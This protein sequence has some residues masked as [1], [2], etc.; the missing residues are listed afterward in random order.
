VRC[1]STRSRSRRWRCRW[2]CS[3]PRGS[4][5]TRSRASRCRSRTA[6]TRASSRCSATCSPAAARYREALR[7]GGT[8]EAH[9]NL[10]L[11]A[12]DDGRYEEALHGFDRALKLDPTLVEVQ[13]NRANVLVEL[14]RLDEAAEQF[15]HLTHDDEVAGPAWWGLAA[16]HEA[17]GD[18]GEAVAARLR[19]LETEPELA[20]RCATAPVGA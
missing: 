19:A 5:P 15:V 9:A 12:V 10:A 4:S 7:A 18:C 14:G 8:P 20:R 16:V 6:P 17:R 13:L 2:S 11:L 1:R 3:S